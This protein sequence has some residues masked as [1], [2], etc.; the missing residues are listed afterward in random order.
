MNWKRS[1]SRA[2]SE[3]FAISRK[4]VG[5]RRG[6]R[7]LIYHSVNSM[8]AQVPRN[9]PRGIFTVH[10]RLFNVHIKNLVED[11]S[12]SVVNLTEGLVTNSSDMRTIAIT[13]DDG[14]KDNL[15]T[16]APILVDHGIPF[17][18]FVT[19]DFIQDENPEFL[20]P[21]ELREL[22]KLPGV[23]IG[24][25]GAT[26]TPLTELDDTMLAKEL[27]SGKKYLEDLTGKEITS[28]SYPHG[29]VDKRVRD[30]VKKA[31]YKLG[32]SSFFGINTASHDLFMLYRTCILGSDSV[33]VFRQK[34]RGDWDWY[35]WLQHL[36]M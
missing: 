24:V 26:H 12:L 30:A 14:Y 22:S 17:T 1:I 19:S 20:T 21:G 7:A 32:A 27:S 35:R 34:L 2:I 28:I 15:Y 3:L 8:I 36:S 6:F 9:D 11:S 29:R 33:R 13:F 10:P 5:I 18:V 23:H 4:T 16:V 25:H 31:G